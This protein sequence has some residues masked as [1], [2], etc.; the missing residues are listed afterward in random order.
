M[1]KKQRRLYRKFKRY[2]PKLTKFF[3]K[4]SRKLKKVLK[5][6][7]NF[8]YGPSMPKERRHIYIT[9]ISNFI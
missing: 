1:S 8:Y 6:Y 7:S 4:Y 9:T 3:I 5:A 2:A